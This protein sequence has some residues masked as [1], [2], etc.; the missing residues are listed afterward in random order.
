[1]DVTYK[2]LK[3]GYILK[4]NDSLVINDTTFQVNCYFGGYGYLADLDHSSNAEIFNHTKTKDKNEWASKFGKIH[5]GTGEH[6]F[7]ELDMPNLTAFVIAIYEDIDPSLCKLKHP[8]KNN[9]I[10]NLPKHNTSMH[11][12]L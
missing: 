10:V 9:I 1:M 12:K 11:I 8:S 6:G 3:K 5:G 4:E 2:D 7:P